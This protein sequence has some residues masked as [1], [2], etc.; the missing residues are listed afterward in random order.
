MARSCAIKMSIWMTGP[1]FGQDRVGIQIDHPLSE[2]M[3]DHRKKRVKRVAKAPPPSGRPTSITQMFNWLV[4]SVGRCW[5]LL[6]EK[7]VVFGC[8]RTIVASVLWPCGHDTQWL[9]WWVGWWGGWCNVDCWPS[10]RTKH[11]RRGVT[12]QIWANDLKRRWSWGV[13]SHPSN[14]T[15]HSC[16]VKQVC[17][18]S[19]GCQR[20]SPQ[21][22]MVVGIR[23][24][25]LHNKGKTQRSW[26]ASWSVRA[27]LAARLVYGSWCPC[28]EIFWT[29]HERSSKI[30]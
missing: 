2:L 29:L 10:F 22:K 15:S 9:G 12:E 27:T 7:V 16:G 30:G 17:R 8:S 11:F 24:S 3:L 1:T 21:C 23:T 6:S 26:G 20:N 14:L 5:K 4:D 18:A 28:C 19:A 13:T 25:R